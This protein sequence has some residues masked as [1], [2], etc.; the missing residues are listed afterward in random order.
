MFVLKKR[1][2]LANFLYLCIKILP[3]NDGKE[4]K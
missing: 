4:V 1:L 3:Y 2:S